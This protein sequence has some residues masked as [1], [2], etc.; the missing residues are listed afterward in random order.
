MLDENWFLGLGGLFSKIWLLSDKNKWARYKTHETFCEHLLFTLVCKI[1]KISIVTKITGPSLITATDLVAQM[2]KNLP[3][4]HGTGVQSLSWEDPLEKGVARHFSI[5][6]W[7][8][9]GQKSLVGYYSWG[10]KE[11]D[12]TEQLTHV[13]ITFQKGRHIVNISM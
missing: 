4:M 9:H 13:K 5:L 6:V 2:V 8:I 1:D 11:S 12:T 10:C 7:S 3:A